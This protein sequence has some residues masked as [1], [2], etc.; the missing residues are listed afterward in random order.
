MTNSDQNP[1]SRISTGPTVI[2][3][4]AVLAETPPSASAPGPAAAVPARAGALV[5]LIWACAFVAVFA[6]LAVWV[7]P[8]YLT[9]KAGRDS[10]TAGREILV[11]GLDAIAEAC[12]PTV[13]VHNVISSTI[14]RLDP[15]RKLVVH[16]QNIDVEVNRH[17]E[18]RRIWEMIPWS[19]ATVKLKVLDNRV[20]LYIPFDEL[21]EKNFIFDRRNNSLTIEVPKLKIDREM[22]M[23]QSDPAK[24]FE[25]KRGS[26]VPFG[27]DVE[28]LSYDARSELENEV[29]RTANKNELMWLAAR[30]AAQKALEQ[31]FSMMRSSL[32]ENVTLQIYLP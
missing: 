4:P 13:N 3:S 26:W 10:A 9:E 6:I 8:L 21:S 24:I 32:A 2:T 12:R 20:Q 14:G 16:T 25:E 18:I 11:R 1:E 29:I 27:V 30:D 7:L 5:H 19:K 23:V 17:G 28:E 22:V 31:L 15:T